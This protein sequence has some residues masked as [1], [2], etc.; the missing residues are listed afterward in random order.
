LLGLGP[1]SRERHEVNTLYGSSFPPVAASVPAARRGVVGCLRTHGL[2]AFADD[3]ALLTS[4]LVS[5]AVLHACTPVAVCVGWDGSHLQVQ[6]ADDSAEA[7]Q[8]QPKR[9]AEP[10]GRG[11]EIVAAIAQR[12]GFDPE[13]DGKVVWFEL[14]A[15][16]ATGSR[17]VV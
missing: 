17:A 12:W 16:A 4:E 3:A 5:N 15:P 13:A 10:G 7:P 1:G 6:V 11:L 14:D 9:P 8:Q 2:T